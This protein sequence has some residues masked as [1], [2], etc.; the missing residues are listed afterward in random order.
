MLGAGIGLAGALAV[1][2]VLTAIAA[3]LPAHDPLAVVVLA[4]ALMAVAL[5][6]CWLPARRAAALDPMVA[7][8]HE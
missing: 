3:E 4:A 2:P 7:L 6:A 8:R 5:F 1:A